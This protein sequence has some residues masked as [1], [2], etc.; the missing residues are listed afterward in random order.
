MPEFLVR[1]IL[2]APAE[3]LLDR[4]GKQLVFLQHHGDGVAQR[5]QI[6]VAHVHAAERQLSGSDIIQARDELHE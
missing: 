5:L 1:G 4:A 6:I 3:V 2:I